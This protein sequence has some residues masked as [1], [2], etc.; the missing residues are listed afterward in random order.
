MFEALP[1]NGAAARTLLSAACDWLAAEGANAARLGFGSL[2]SPFACDAYDA[3]PP[4]WL[5]QNP[6]YYHAL[7]ADAGF[8]PERRFV[9]YKIEVRPELVTRWTAA[10]DAARAAGFELVRL[11]DVPPAR[12]ASEFTSVW[13]DAFEAHWGQ[14]PFSRAE[15]ESLMDALAP[16]GM[17]EL[18]LL[19]Y[20]RGTPAGVIWIVGPTAMLAL[21][22]DV[23]DA[24][25][26]NN[27]GIGVSASARGRGLNLAL[28]SHA[29]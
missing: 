25:R 23:A 14:V 27:L 6:A 20:E 29:F 12:R 18:S 28:A 9:D 8:A 3:L 5:R 1:E 13:N 2:E 21:G 15:V 4:S 22:R 19:A 26:L 24:E 16:S 11:R 7:F 10:V 17:L